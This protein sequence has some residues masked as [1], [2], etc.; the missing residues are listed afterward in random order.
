MSKTP[1]QY[2]KLRGR[3]ATLTHYVKLYMGADHLLQVFST[4]FTES[5]KRFYFG[6]IQA[7]TIRKTMVGKIVNAVLGTIVAAFAAFALST[8][9]T[10][11]LVLG[12]IAAC[13]AFVLGINVAWGPT[14]T[15]YLRTAVQNEKL[16]SLSRLRRARRVLSHLQPQILAF[17]GGISDQEV[18]SRLGGAAPSSP[19]SLPPVI[20]AT[21]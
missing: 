2:R 13:F 7:I 15:C 12:S 17:Q 9:D 16:P 8:S 20:S 21:G 19:G 14:C 11:A 10:V 4:G 6:D 5:Y 1:K 3:G 18:Q